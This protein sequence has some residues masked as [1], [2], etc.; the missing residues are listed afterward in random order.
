VSDLTAFRDHAAE[1]AAAVHKPDCRAWVQRP[2]MWGWQDGRWVTPDPKCAGC[3][4]D[5]DRATWAR[6]AAEID[7]YLTTD[8]TALW[9]ES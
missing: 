6:L 5:A 8:D 2:N 3:V 7:A 4:T 1:M 9:E